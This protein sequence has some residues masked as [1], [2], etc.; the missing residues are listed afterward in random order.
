MADA[1]LVAWRSLREVA[2]GGRAEA[3]LRRELEGAGL[4]GADRRLAYE[5]TLGSIRWRGL[6][7]YCLDALLNRPLHQTRPALRELLR[8]GA[9]QLL[10]LERVPAYAA[11]NSSVE[12]AR[13]DPET[14]GATGLVNAVLRRLSRERP[15]LP[16]PV[17][18]PVR[19]LSVSL[20]HPR[21]LVERWLERFGPETTRRLLESDNRPRPTFVFGAPPADAVAEGLYEPLTAFPDC[22]RYLGEDDLN[23][24][25]EHL[26]GAIYAADPATIL[27]PALLAPTP[28]ELVLDAAAAPGGK[29]SHLRRLGGAR[30][31]LAALELSRTRLAGLAAN[32]RRRRLKV[33]LVGGDLNAAPFRGRVFD[34]LLL[35]APCSNTGVLARRVEARWRLEPDDPQRLADS[36]LRLLRSAAALV[37]RGGRL[38]YSTCS[39][40]REENEEVVRRFLAKRKDYAPRRLDAGSL[41]AAGLPV[42]AFELTGGFVRTSPVDGRC[43]GAFVAVLEAL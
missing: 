35:D 9:Y 40:E 5:L 12:L 19:H 39:L 2:R 33:G 30:L 23:S 36:Q 32:V 16:D 21:W 24:R 13:R 17:A 27:A 20:S 37:R 29:T 25:K 26:A 15:A 10:R 41:E 22:W 1:R 43:D 8:L 38:V 42:E 18:D 31:R 7:D 4:G 34:A 14:S 6:L 11:V 28:G 3:A